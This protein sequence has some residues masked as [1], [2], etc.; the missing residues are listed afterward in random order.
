LSFHLL[1]GTHFNW[2]K[3]EHCPSICSVE[4][5]PTDT[6]WSIVL[7]SAPWNAFQLIQNGALSFHLLRGTHFNWYK[8]EHCPSIHSMEHIST[9]TKWSVVLPSALWNTFQPIQNG[10]LSML[11]CYMLLVSCFASQRICCKHGGGVAW[12]WSK[13]QLVQDFVIVMDHVISSHIMCS[14]IG[15]LQVYQAVLFTR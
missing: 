12:K 3:M 5:I 11:C 14:T 1:R 7:P 10:A 4:R 8:M 9:D 2:C 6:K 15:V 13:H